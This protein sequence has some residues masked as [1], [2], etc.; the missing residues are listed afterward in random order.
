MSHHKHFNHESQDARRHDQHHDT[1]PHEK[2][3]KQPSKVMQHHDKH[4]HVRG[5]RKR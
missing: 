1:H 5:N 2:I 4:G 3:S